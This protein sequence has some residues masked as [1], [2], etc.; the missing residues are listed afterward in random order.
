MLKSMVLL[1]SIGFLPVLSDMPEK[2]V[3]AAGLFNICGATDPMWI[4]VCYGYAL[5]VA[6]VF[7]PP[8]TRFCLDGVEPRIVV[9]AIRSTLHGQTDLHF[10]TAS[11][12]A[13]MAL[14]RHLAC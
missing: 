7:D 4:G 13:L 2:G 5:A 1:F 10:M 9:D 14:D 11:H 3:S 8:R 6:E 12:A